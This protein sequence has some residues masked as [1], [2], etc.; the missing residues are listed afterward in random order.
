M[1]NVATM[2]N[3]KSVLSG[4]WTT[5]ACVGFWQLAG[6]NIPDNAVLHDGS[7]CGRGAVPDAGSVLGRRMSLT[8]TRCIDNDV[9]VELLGV[10][11][12]RSEGMLLDVP[13]LVETLR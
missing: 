10:W 6:G 5:A 11:I 3:W 8:E 1:K 12:V 13:S 2:N 9:L 4:T 7:A